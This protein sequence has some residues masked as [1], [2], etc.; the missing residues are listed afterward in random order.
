MTLIPE[1][2]GIGWLKIREERI[3]SATYT[4]TSFIDNDFHR[5][6]NGIIEAPWEL[7]RR[8]HQSEKARLELQNGT[9]VAI[10]ITEVG[11]N[12]ADFIVGSVNTES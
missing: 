4:I 9:V 7:L 8:A 2:E 12:R 3:G 1:R 5:I 11:T 10:T 6:S